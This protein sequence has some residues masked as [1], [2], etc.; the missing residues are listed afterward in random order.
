MKRNLTNHECAV[1]MMRL[2]DFSN[3]GNSIFGRT[4][5]TYDDKCEYQERRSYTVYSYGQ[6]FPMYVYDFNTGCWYGN[7]DKYSR[8]TSKHQ[9]LMRPPIVEAWMSTDELARL[10]NNGIVKLMERRLAA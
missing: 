3:K 1:H 6:H 10:S 9:S 4:I 2:E 8:T 5:Y 7:R